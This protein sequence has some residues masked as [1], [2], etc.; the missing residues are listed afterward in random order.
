MVVL[1]Y[2]YFYGACPGGEEVVLKIIGQKWL[3]GSNPVCTVIRLGKD[4][5]KSTGLQ[6]RVT[7]VRFGALALGH[8][9]SWLTHRIL[10]PAFTGSSPVC[11]VMAWWQSWFIALD[12]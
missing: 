11:P 12:C 8:W 6:N 3:A 9:R 1:F 10:T 5:W 2:L 4:N 7:P